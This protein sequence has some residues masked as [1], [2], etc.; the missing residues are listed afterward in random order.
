M[1]FFSHHK[2]IPLIIILLIFSCGTLLPGCVGNRFAAR[3]WD[4]LT[5]SGDTLYACSNG[6]FLAIDLTDRASIR[7]LTPV[8]ND[9]GSGSFLGCG[10]SGAPR[11]VAYSAPVVSGSVFYTGTYSG[12]VYAIDTTS[13]AKL[14]EQ[15]TD[16][17]I[18]S[19]PAV[20]EGVVVVTS[21]DKL[22][23]FD[24]GNGAALWSKPF[25]ASGKIWGSP[26]IENGVV[27][28]GSLG[29]KLYALD[30]ETKEEIWVRSFDGAIASTPLI[31]EDTLYIGTFGSRFY[32]LDITSG[33]PR[34]EEPFEGDNWFWTRAT[35]VEGTI[36]VGS[37]G[38]RVYALDSAPGQKKWEYD[39]E[40]GDR[41]RAAPVMAAGVLVV[42]S[43]D[44]N[45]YMIDPE[46]GTQKWGSL[47]FENDILAD[48]W[49]D[50]ETVYLIDRDE[51]IHAIDATTG[52]QEW[53][54]S[55][56]MD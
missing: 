28:F 1:R 4:G 42:G 10:G 21:N 45:V 56:D 41:I 27:Y 16:G 11:L 48:P 31:V 34:W 51:V 25:D 14:W 20:A 6:K 7:D 8:D 26:V 52:T 24:A 49:T 29:H 23:K 35:L 53:S 43:Q 38:G 46:T 22:Y 5:V 30:L 15:V 37:L 55:L 50:G 44:D 18:V 39:T 17:N 32:A 47:H 33:E 9:S 12:E 19:S 54:L 36:Y 40:T 3:G 2:L 13:R